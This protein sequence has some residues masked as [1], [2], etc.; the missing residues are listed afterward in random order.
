MFWV[1]LVFGREKKH[2]ERLGK[3]ANFRGEKKKKEEKILPICGVPGAIYSLGRVF[4]GGGP[5]RATGLKRLQ[6]EWIMTP[7]E[8][9]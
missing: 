7:L 3:K 9:S 1:F 5:S 4:R 2:V 8:R 6:N